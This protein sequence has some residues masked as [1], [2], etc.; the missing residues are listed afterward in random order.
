LYEIF[1]I[2][3]HILLFRFV[4]SPTWTIFKL[5]I[6]LNLYNSLANISAK[7]I[8]CCLFP[9]ENFG[10]RPQRTEFN[11]TNSINRATRDGPIRV[12]AWT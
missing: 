4:L 3:Y 1:S 2:L 10:T 12:V 11:S 7:I 8:E 9:S 6:F 5:N